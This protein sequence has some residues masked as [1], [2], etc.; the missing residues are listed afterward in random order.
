MAKNLI[1]SLVTKPRD[2]KL[3]AKKYRLALGKAYLAGKNGIQFTTKKTFSPSTV[4]YGYGKCPRYW[5]LAT[6]RLNR[7]QQGSASL[8]FAVRASRRLGPDSKIRHHD[9]P[10]GHVHHRHIRPREGHEYG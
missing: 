7:M 6:A 4:G 10:R 9:T 2:T 5:N 3:D 1:G 8:L